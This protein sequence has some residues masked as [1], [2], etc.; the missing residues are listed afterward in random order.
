LDF[1]LPKVGDRKKA[2]A[3]VS[4]AVPTERIDAALAVLPRGLNDAY[5][6]SS[7][8]DFTPDMATAFA[9]RLIASPCEVGAFL[10]DPGAPENIAYAE[11]RTNA[12]NAG[13]KRQRAKESTNEGRRQHPDI[14]QHDLNYLD[15]TSQ[16]LFA[17]MQSIASRHSRP[18]FFSVIM[19][20]QSIAR[21]QRSWFTRE[22]K[23]VAEQFGTRIDQIEWKTEQEEPLLLLPDI[24]GGILCRADRGY[25]DA[26]QAAGKLWD[27]ERVGRFKFQNKAPSQGGGGPGDSGAST[28]PA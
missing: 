28:A 3:F 4:V 22:F 26:R 14:S 24:L 1:S 15:F 8:R 10:C 16:A 9:D 5:L 7:D 21:H 25:D 20:T 18:T 11:H 23:R 12:A 19:D 6:K 13:R 2:L 27:A 17:C